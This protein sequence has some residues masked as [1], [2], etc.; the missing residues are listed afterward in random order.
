MCE[1][2]DNQVVFITN[3]YKEMGVEYAM[4]H[5]QK[6]KAVP[7][8]TL[9][10]MNIDYYSSLT[11]LPQVIE[12]R[13]V[14]NSINDISDLK[15]AVQ[16]FTGCKLKYYAQNTVFSDGK[17][18]SEIMF[19]GEAPGASED[20]QGI[21]FC[22]R[23]GVLLDNALSSI[24]L[25]RKTNF[26]I[27]NTVFWRPPDNRQPTSEEVEICRPFV[28]KHIALCNPKILILVGGVAAT[29][30]LGPKV[31]ISKIR[32]NFYAYNN[33]CLG[34]PIPTTAI[35]HPAYLLRQPLQKKVF[36]Y[37]LLNIQENLS[38]II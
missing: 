22:G 15:S 21:P 33:P 35:F 17:F 27:T 7:Q 32:N 2:K 36:W 9:K 19:I 12:A 23:S 1:K 16:N 28:E 37:D 29:S 24:G 25:Y 26:Y 14:A 13:K 18:G 3:W 8:N 38:K 5:K 6:E 11:E 10:L 34:E 31:Q 20:E 30:L 4:K